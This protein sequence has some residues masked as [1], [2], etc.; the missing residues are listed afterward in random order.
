MKFKIKNEE[1]ELKYSF[2]INIFFEQIQGHSLDFA[3]I[4]SEDLIVLFYCTVITS[5]QK[6]KKP[7]IT[8]EDFYDAVDDNGGE[9]CIVD[10]SNW[11]IEIMKAQYEMLEMTETEEDKKKAKNTNTKKKN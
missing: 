10:F 8:M 7:I 3:A 2:R 5:L 4:S 6:E 9:H 11:Y 1:I